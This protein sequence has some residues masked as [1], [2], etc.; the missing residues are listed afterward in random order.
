MILSGCNKKDKTNYDNYS[1]GLNDLGLYEGLETYEIT[2]PD[3]S[4]LTFTCDE[5]LQWNVSYLFESDENSEIKTVDDYVY[6]YGE[7]FLMLLGLTSKDIAED[8][9]RATVSLEFYVNDKKLD[10]YTTTQSYVVSK[11]GDSIVSSFIGHKAKDSYYVDYT[12]PSD[13]PYYPSKTAKVKVTVNSIH[14]KDPIKNGVVE[15]NL[16]A[17]AKQL[18]NVTDTDSFLKALRPKIALSTID[19]FLGDYVK[20]NLDVQVPEAYIEYEMYRMKFRLQ[21]IGYTYDEYLIASKTTND[22][23]VAYCKEIAK[24][25]VVYMSVFQSMNTEITNEMISKYYGENT[26]YIMEI[27]GE[28]YMRLNIMRDLA[29]QEIANRVVITNN[30]QPIDKNV[31]DKTD[32]TDK[33]TQPTVTDP[34]NSK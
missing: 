32:E 21:Q 20:N 3:F 29:L 18:D 12:F 9:D 14:M 13:D 8:G 19:A 10:D 7:E 16:D 22:E 11:D 27:Q 34:S 23:V 26:A 4:K 33:E 25:N 15:N 28:P 17:I 1:Y 2:L 5:I 24:D 6:Y 31:S 30:G